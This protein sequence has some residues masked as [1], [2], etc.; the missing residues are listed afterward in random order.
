MGQQQ[1]LL[2]VLATVIVGLATVAGIEAFDENQQ[3]AAQ[4]VITQR[5]VDIAADMQ[6]LVSKPVQ[7][8]GVDLSTTSADSIAV[9]LGLDGATVPVQGAGND[10]DC[11]IQ[12]P[13]TTNSK[14]SVALECS[15]DDSPQ[16][17]TITLI[18]GNSGGEEVQTSFN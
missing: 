15:S 4:D 13:G 2:L 9:K 5:G 3:Q 8:G 6:G 14:W 18:P 17:A 1:L 16:T 12:S 7:L 11:V 10:A